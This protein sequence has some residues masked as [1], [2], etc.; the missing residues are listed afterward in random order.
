LPIVVPP[1][2]GSDARQANRPNSAAWNA[3]I[4]MLSPFFIP[5]PLSPRAVGTKMRLAPN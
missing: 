4:A 1:M 3:L 5:Q 2:P